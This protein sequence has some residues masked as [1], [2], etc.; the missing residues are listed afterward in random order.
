MLTLKVMSHRVSQ[1]FMGFLLF[2]FHVL[3]RRE[4]DTAS[5]SS[6]VTTS[7]AILLICS[8]EIKI[9][10]GVSDFKYNRVVTVVLKRMLEEVR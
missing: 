1:S 10:I 7:I 6:H 9:S 2:S 4:K 5:R 8:V 3:K